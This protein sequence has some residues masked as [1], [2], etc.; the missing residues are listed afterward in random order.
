MPERL[1]PIDAPRY[2]ANCTARFECLLPSTG[3]R[4]FGIG[5]CN[6]IVISFI[7]FEN[8]RIQGFKQKNL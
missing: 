4:I 3:S 1:F 7:G 6:F 8:S 2:P 5:H